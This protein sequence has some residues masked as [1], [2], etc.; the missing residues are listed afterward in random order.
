MAKQKPSK[1][2]KI[3]TSVLMSP[4][5]NKQVDDIIGVMG[6]G[7]RS[8]SKVIEYAVDMWHQNLMKEEEDLL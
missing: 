4:R 2:G 1:A 7:D 3:A 6:W 5:T 8:R